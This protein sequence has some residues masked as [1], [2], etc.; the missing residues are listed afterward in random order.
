MPY[1]YVAFVLVVGWFVINLVN[2]GAVSKYEITLYS[3]DGKA[4]G[5]KV[6]E[7]ATMPRPERLPVA[8]SY[9]PIKPIKFLD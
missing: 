3:D 7:R 6:I 8:K 9:K 4:V 5:T 2:K 1:W